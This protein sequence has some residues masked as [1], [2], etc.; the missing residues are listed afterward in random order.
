MCAT[1]STVPN[2][3]VALLTELFHHVFYPPGSICLIDFT[4]LQPCP[5]NRITDSPDSLFSFLLITTVSG[6]LHIFL[7][8]ATEIPGGEVSYREACSK[9]SLMGV[10]PGAVF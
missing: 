5:E 3:R 1:P 6:E 7:F 10:L 9:H 2:N 4:R 8:R